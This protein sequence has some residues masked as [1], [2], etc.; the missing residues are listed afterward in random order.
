MPKDR[1]QNGRNYVSAT[2]TFVQEGRR[3]AVRE[4]YARCTQAQN[5]PNSHLNS[6]IE[7]PG[8]KNDKRWRN[9]LR[10][11]ML[12]EVFFFDG[13]RSQ[14]DC[15][16]QVKQDFLTLPTHTLENRISR[17]FNQARRQ[18]NQVAITTLASAAGKI[19]QEYANAL[20]PLSANALKVVFIDSTVNTDTP[21]YCFVYYK[22]DMEF[23]ARLQ[24][25]G[26]TDCAN[27]KAFTAGSWN[28][29]GDLALPANDAPFNRGIEFP[30]NFSEESLIHELLH[31]C[32]DSKYE[33]YTWDTYHTDADHRQIV[34]EATTEWL[35]RNVT[36]QWNQGGYTNV[37]PYIKRWIDHG[38]ITA[39]ELKDAYFKGTNER[40][41]ADK[42]VRLYDADVQWTAQKGQ[43]DYLIAQYKFA[44]ID[45]TKVTVKQTIFNPLKNLP[46]SRWQ[47]LTPPL[48]NWTFAEAWKA[49]IRAAKAGKP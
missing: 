14:K 12:L 34:R 20:P 40:T 13:G 43:L 9:A 2:P 38:D 36:K 32:T 35:T 49:K 7:L 42:L 3:E 39:D 47:D 30:P 11:L 41:F 19:R 5:D 16:T 17:G 44:T 31:W 27:P 15:I 22:T 25:L 24:E 28:K 21:L 6:L 8:N 4:F 1:I 18:L 29:P 48:N 10:T 37:Y 23:R 33:Q 46:E 45:P 26:A